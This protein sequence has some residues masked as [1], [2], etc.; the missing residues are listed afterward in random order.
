MENEFTKSEVR[1]VKASLREAIRKLTDDKG[2]DCA[3]EPAPSS[4]M[5][6]PAGLAA[7]DTGA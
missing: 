4:Q 6:E 5:D 1:Q 2:T 3:A 7:R